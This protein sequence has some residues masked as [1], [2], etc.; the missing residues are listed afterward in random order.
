VLPTERSRFAGMVTGV[1]RAYGKAPTDADM[2]AWWT[3]CHELSIEAL[4]SALKSHK[5][6]PDRG[7]KV[8]RPVDI[9][10]RMKAGNRSAEGCAATDH[11][12]RCSYPGIFSDGTAGEGQWW[13]P[14]HRQD[15]TGPEASRWIETSRNV[16]WEVA[17]ERRAIR[18]LAESQRTP[19]VR[20]TAWDIAK[21]HGDRPWSG[22]FAKAETPA[23]VLEPGEMG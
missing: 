11:T 22:S 14:W 16:L 6:D 8:P 19:S 2:E 13:C 4:Q 3:E 15:R 17:R 10:R 18:M 9:T 20:N 23:E 12:G 21:R 7:E 5:E 1:L